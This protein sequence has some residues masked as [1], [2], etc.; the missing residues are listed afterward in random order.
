MDVSASGQSPLRRAEQGS[1]HMKLLQP[2]GVTPETVTDI[3][4][5]T[6]HTNTKKAKQS[7]ADVDEEGNQNEESKWHLFLLHIVCCYEV[8]HDGTHQAG[9]RRKL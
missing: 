4:A 1:D 5:K 8:L 9:S 2:V 3:Y 6:H 7:L